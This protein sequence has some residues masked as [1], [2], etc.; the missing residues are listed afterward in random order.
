MDYSIYTAA[1]LGP[2]GL[3]MFR[4]RKDGGK[5][6]RKDA[7]KDKDIRKIRKNRADSTTSRS[8]HS[9]TGTIGSGS[10]A[11]ATTSPA[12]AKKPLIYNQEYYGFLEKGVDELKTDYVSG[13]R[14]MAGKALGMLGTAIELAA[15]TA[16]DGEELWGMGVGAARV[17]G[18]A[19]G[20]MRF[21]FSVFS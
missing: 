15:M 9:T 14:E 1:N 13:A 11:T 5:D 7:R 21:V 12:K 20:S 6:A 3:S 16:R 2:P 10:T 19:R 4:S 17:L 8:T 18:E